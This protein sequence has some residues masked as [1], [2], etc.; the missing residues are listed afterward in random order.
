MNPPL[1]GTVLPKGRRT[2][3]ASVAAAIG[4]LLVPGAILAAEPASPAAILE[5]LE[6]FRTM[7]TVL[8]V[9]AHPDDE[10]TQLITYFAKGRH[11]RAGYLSVTR[12]DGG[13]NE[14]GP[15]FDAELGIART[16]ELLAARRIDGGRQFFTRALDF[17]YSKTVDE[18]LRIWDKEQ[19]LG[20]VVRVIRMFRPDVVVAQFFPGPQPGNHGHHNSSAILALEAFSLAGDPQAYPEHFEDGLTPWQPTRIIQGG[21]GVDT[22][23]TDPATGSTFGELSSLSRSRHMTQ[24]GI[25]NPNVGRGGRGGGGGR[26]GPGGGRG[27]GRGGGGL[28]VLAGAPATEDPME[29]IDTT[30]TRVAGGAEIGRMADAII[31]AFNPADPSASVPALLELRA[32]LA[33][34]PT[35]DVVVDEKRGDLDRIVQDTLGLTVQTTIENAEV[36]PGET[37]ALTHSVSMRTAVPIRWTGM[38]YPNSGST[39]P[40]F[41][42]VAVPNG[43][44]VSRSLS[45]ALPSNS[46]VSQPYWLRELAAPGLFTVRSDD[47]PLI[48][49]PENPPA[50]PVEYVFEIGGQTLVLSDEPRQPDTNAAGEDRPRQLSVISP[51]TVHFSSIVSVVRPGTSGPLTVELRANRA[52]MSGTLELDLPAGWTATP[53]S[54]P[55][56]LAGAGSTGRFTFNVTATTRTDSSNIGAHVTVD[57]QRYDTDRVVID[58]NHIPLQLLQP[59]ALA[60]AVSVDLQVSGARVGYFPGAGDDIAECLEQMGYEVRILTGSDLNPQGL[61]GLAAVVIGVRAFDEKPELNAN[62]EGLLAWVEAGGTVIAQYNRSGGTPRVA[63]FMLNFSGG[64]PGRRTTDEDAPVTFLAPQHRALT[65]PNRIGPADF[66]GWVQERGTYYPSS[67]DEDAFT[68]ILSMND[69]GEEP[70]TGSLLVARHGSGTYVYTGIAFF[71]QLPKGVPGAYRLFANL[72]ELG[73]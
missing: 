56:R 21:G 2:V 11:Y 1:P 42:P 48:G 50:F 10:N 26:G 4:F 5:A 37:M 62:I 12:G 64:A 7:G 3:R 8:Q 16:Q 51:V 43:N 71:R 44:P 9:A 67:W 13:Q 47:R 29:G 6:T 40:A 41:S 60:K 70:L 38:R 22:N 49:L 69:P 52:N 39:A 73:Q 27:G 45:V 31:A 61:A 59:R 35:G 17:G 19:V 15:E 34:I 33:T 57:G 36:V 23:G 32:R 14:I 63:P 72:I 30:W 54:Q 20:D 28:N 25:P 55:F 18:T 58:Y 68:P 46:R 24:F 53:A 66:T 65:T